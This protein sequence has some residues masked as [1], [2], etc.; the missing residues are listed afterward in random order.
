[1]AP[2]EGQEELEEV[3]QE[4]K[5]AEEEVS[6]EEG[7]WRRCNEPPPALEAHIRILQQ[8]QFVL[9]AGHFLRCPIS[10]FSSEE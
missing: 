3:S 4:I 10:G 9:M 1:M 6:L 5:K 7:D 8:Q 2:D